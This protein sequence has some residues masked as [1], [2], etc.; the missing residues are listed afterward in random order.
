MGKRYDVVAAIEAGKD[1]NGQER[2]RWQKCGVA[3]E[4]DGK[5]RVKLDS[6]PIA[7][8]DGWLNLFEPKDK[9]EHERESQRSGEIR[10]DIPF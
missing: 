6:I 5:L 9:P 7:G 2:T 1:G 8:W 10:D 3:F 4:R